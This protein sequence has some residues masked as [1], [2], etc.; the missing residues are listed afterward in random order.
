MRASVSW[1]SGFQFKNFS[2]DK[3]WFLARL[4]SFKTEFYQSV[5]KGNYQTL[6]WP[7]IIKGWLDAKHTNKP[8]TEKNSWHTLHHFY[9]L[10]FI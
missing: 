4:Y 7:L 10:V 8:K 9:F 2:K 1:G 6:N 3:N 5:N